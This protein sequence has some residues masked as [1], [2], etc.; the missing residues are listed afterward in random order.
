MPLASEAP[1]NLQELNDYRKVRAAHWDRVA[2]RDNPPLWLGGYYHRRLREVYRS[3]SVG[4]Q[5]VLEIGC[6]QG[7]L[8]AGLDTEFALGVDISKEML[9]R[10]KKR[11][12]TAHFILSDGQCL[13]LT[14]TYDLIVLSDTLNEVWD[15]QRL[16]SEVARLSGPDTRIVVNS[17]SHLWQLPLSLAQRLGLGRPQADQN[18]LT[19]E[20]VENLQHLVG[21]EP[22]RRWAEVLLPIDIPLVTPLFNKVLAKIAPFAWLCLSNFSVARKS[23][24]P[25]AGVPTVSVIVAARNEAGN[26]KSLVRRLPTLG[27][28]TELIFVEGHSTDDTYKVIEDVIQHS[29]QL[30][31]KLFR[32][33]G[34]GKGDAVRLGFEKASGDILMILDADLSVPPE[35]LPRFYKALLQRKGEFINGVRLVYPMEDQAMRYAN[36]IGNKLFSRLFSWIFGQPVK[37]TL[38]GT[39]VLTRAHYAKIAANREYFGDFDPFGDYDLLFGAA[40]LNL[41]IVDL[42][43][44]YRSRRYGSTNISRWRD[45]WLLL[46]MT[47]FAARKIKFI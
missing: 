8:V 10:A 37:D 26:I 14:G 29:P 34:R 28:H 47:A 45:G 3:L 27:S 32:Q 41:K 39:K 13:P 23:A 42:P 30:D 44:R 9:N 20:D 36:L 35:D 2:T 22:I 16:L 46:R 5:R 1:S 12:P 18:W 25:V 17:Y 33:T 6:G 38:C 7:D 31:A 40:R 15:V 24:E 19:P 43:I 4:R 11:H 21:L